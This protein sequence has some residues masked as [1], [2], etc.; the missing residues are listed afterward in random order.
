[1][2]LLLPGKLSEINKG[3]VIFLRLKVEKE[4]RDKIKCLFV[5]HLKKIFYFYCYL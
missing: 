2:K 5:G 1:M 4:K 3:S